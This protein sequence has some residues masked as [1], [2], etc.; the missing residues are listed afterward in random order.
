MCSWS[1][2]EPKDIQIE[3]DRETHTESQTQTVTLRETDTDKHG[4]THPATHIQTDQIRAT[5]RERETTIQPTDFTPTGR[6]SDKF[7]ICRTIG[8]SE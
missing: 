1:L 4:H 7:Y 5:E 8:T 6:N 2:Q 3:T